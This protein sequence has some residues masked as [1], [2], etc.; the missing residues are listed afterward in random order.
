MSH[1][2]GLRRL[3]PTGAL[4]VGDPPVAVAA[5]LQAVEATRRRAPAPGSRAADP[6]AHPADVR[7]AAEIEAMRSVARRAFPR[8]SDEELDR[9]L[10]LSLEEAAPTPSWPAVLAVALPVGVGTLWASD[11]VGVALATLLGA[12]TRLAAG[13]RG[14]GAGLGGAYVVAALAAGGLAF[15]LGAAL[16]RLDPVARRLVALLHGLAGLGVLFLALQTRDLMQVLVLFL[17]LGLTFGVAAGLFRGPVRPWFTPDGR[18]ARAAL[19]TRPYITA[20]AF[21]NLLSGVAIFVVPAFHKLF[22]EVGVHL[23]LPT[24]L[25]LWASDLCQDY[26]V[27]TW[28]LFV[29]APLPL[30]RLSPRREQPAFLAALLLGLFLLGSTVGALFAPL[31]ELLQKL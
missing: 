23:P 7:N 4:A 27:V 31:F 8:L 14:P 21:A 2:D 22:R 29:L 1:D 12:A 25:V 18:A 16:L 24:E 30:L 6:D 19:T 10:A 20:V 9:A 17:F 15:F 3:A 13:E 28:P 26:S 11:G 5:I